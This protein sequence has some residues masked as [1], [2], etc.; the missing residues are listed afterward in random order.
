MSALTSIA[1]LTVYALSG[2]V[3]DS[4]VSI[5]KESVAERVTEPLHSRRHAAAGWEADLAA[6]AQEHTLSKEI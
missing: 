3:A 1:S 5:H 2:N 6:A 4:P